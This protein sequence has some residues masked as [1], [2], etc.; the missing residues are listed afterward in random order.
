MGNNDA[1]PKLQNP[2]FLISKKNDD[3]SNSK[4]NTLNNI[5]FHLVSSSPWQLYVEIKN[6]IKVNN[7]PPISSYHLKYV[8][9]KDVTTMVR[10]LFTDPFKS[11]VETISSIIR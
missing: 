7:F 3:D 5:S 4:N 11:K 8:R 2:S 10:K 6:F 9:P 1:K